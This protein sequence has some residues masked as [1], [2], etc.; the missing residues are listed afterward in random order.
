M[1]WR[2]LML[3]QVPV[4]RETISYGLRNRRIGL[5]V[6]SSNTNVE[7]DFALLAPAGVTVHSARSGGYDLNAIPDS[8]E[9]R[10]FAR[11]SM[12]S[13]LPLLSDARVDVIAYGCT[14]ATLSDGP[15]FDREFSEELSCKSGRPAVTTAGALIEALRSIGAKRVAFTSPYV[16]RL[17]GEGVG[18]IQ[19]CGI[20]V[21]NEVAFDRELNSIEQNALTPQDAY[22]MA[23]RADHRDA[24]AVVISCTDYRALEA[25]PA[26][27]RR[28]GKPVVTSNQALMF[29]CLNRLN[30]NGKHLTAGGSLFTRQGLCRLPSPNA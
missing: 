19:E 25:V 23:L 5:V 29:A 8:E 16:R 30:I 26:I 1:L 21:V 10:R 3:N 18:F 13:Y 6:P 2:I 20:E 15:E 14:S 12:D 11:R 7:P 4:D 27:E 22:D 28:I 17:S 24:D 9:M